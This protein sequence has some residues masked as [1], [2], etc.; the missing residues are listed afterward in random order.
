MRRI[1]QQGKSLWLLVGPQG[2]TVAEYGSYVE[3]FYHS[4]FGKAPISVIEAE[5]ELA[6]YRR[7]QKATLPSR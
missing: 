1:V 3:A 2:E 5:K 7:R 4:L 6:K